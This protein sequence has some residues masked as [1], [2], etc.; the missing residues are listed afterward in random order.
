MPQYQ[1][2]EELTVYSVDIC[3]RDYEKGKHFRKKITLQNVL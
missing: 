1:H 3:A 2:F